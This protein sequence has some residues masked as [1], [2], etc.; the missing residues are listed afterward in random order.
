MKLVADGHGWPES[1]KGVAGSAGPP[2][3]AGNQGPVDLASQQSAGRG[4]A[5]IRVP[6]LVQ[7]D[8]LVS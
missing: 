4:R 6:P 3:D 2:V 7:L 8:V 5:E 1:G